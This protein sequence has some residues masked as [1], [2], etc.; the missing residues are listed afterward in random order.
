VVVFAFISQLPAY[1]AVFGL[2]GKRFAIY[3]PLNQYFP[4]NAN[5][6]DQLLS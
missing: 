3:I 6:Y 5:E 1:F 2:E 4:D